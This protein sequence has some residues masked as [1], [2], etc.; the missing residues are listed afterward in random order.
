MSAAQAFEAVYTAPVN[1]ALAAAQRRQN[2]SRVVE[3][4]D[5]RSRQGAATD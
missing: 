3:Q 5:P 2:R 4:Y 1:A